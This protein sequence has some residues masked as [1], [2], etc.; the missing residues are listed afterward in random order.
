VALFVIIFGVIISKYITRLFKRA[1][2]K[3][4][5]DPSM[6]N[7]LTRS[8]ELIILS[9]HNHFCAKCSRLGDI[10]TGLLTSADASAIVFD[11]AFKRYW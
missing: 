1:I 11:L 5:D 4:S 6:I 3:K 2:F 8:L 7:S 9:S 10:A